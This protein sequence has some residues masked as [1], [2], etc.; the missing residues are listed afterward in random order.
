MSEVARRGD[1]VPDLLFQVADFGKATVF[2]AAPDLLLIDPDL[3]A[4]STGRCQGDLSQFFVERGEELLRIPCGAQQPTT[5]IAIVDG[6][7]VFRCRYF[8]IGHFYFGIS[9]RLHLLASCGVCQTRKATRLIL[10]A[11]L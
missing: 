8:S 11:R 10:I 6:D 7:S 4:P 5:S 3:E 9:Y 2:L 1:D